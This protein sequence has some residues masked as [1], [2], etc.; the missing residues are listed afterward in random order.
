MLAMQV[1][2][3]SLTKQIKCQI[4]CHHIHGAKYTPFPRVLMH[5]DL[6]RELKKKKGKQKTH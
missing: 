3:Y 6:A 1:T 4:D 2:L 5:K